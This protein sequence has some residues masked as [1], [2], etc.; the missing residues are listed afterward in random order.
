MDKDIGVISRAIDDPSSPFFWKAGKPSCRLRVRM[1]GKKIG[2]HNSRG[3]GNKDCT[4]FKHACRG[5]VVKKCI[6]LG[7]WRKKE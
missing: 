6:R 7:L 2:S 1:E 3:C 5:N 4:R